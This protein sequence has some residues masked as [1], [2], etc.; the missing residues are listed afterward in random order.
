MS[1]ISKTPIEKK[2]TVQD[3]YKTIVKSD[4]YTTTGE[5]IIIVKDVKLCELT[6]NSMSTKSVKIKALSDTVVKADYS[7]DIKYDEIFLGNGA[8]IDLE[9]VEDGWYVMSSDGLKDS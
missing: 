4:K 5:S 2:I 7:I 6:L 1:V 9:F 3:S 8:S